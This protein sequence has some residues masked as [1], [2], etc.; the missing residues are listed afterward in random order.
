VANITLKNEFRGLKGLEDF[1]RRLAGI[2]RR[3][4]RLERGN[5]HRMEFSVTDIG[6]FENDL[7]D[8]VVEAHHRRLGLKVHDRAEG[9]E[10]AAARKAY[11]RKMRKRLTTRQSARREYAIFNA[12]FSPEFIIQ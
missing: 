6:I 11:E 5:P 7:A 10:R 8:A 2:E 4:K 12:L 3:F 1:D 9:S